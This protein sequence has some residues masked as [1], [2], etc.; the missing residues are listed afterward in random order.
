[1]SLTSDTRVGL[2]VR[3]HD[4][5]VVCKNSVFMTYGG[6]VDGFVQCDAIFRAMIVSRRRVVRYCAFKQSDYKIY[7]SQQLCVVCR[8]A[9]ASMM[10][11]NGSVI[12]C[13]IARGLGELTKRCV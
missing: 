6:I 2:P 8:V 3:E 13:R 5:A 9:L 10:Q 1:M 4:A 12:I 11:Q 7:A